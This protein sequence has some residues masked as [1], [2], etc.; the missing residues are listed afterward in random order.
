VNKEFMNGQSKEM[1]EVQDQLDKQIE[2]VKLIE[3][4]IESQDDR[5]FDQVMQ[6]MAGNW[7]NRI[8]KHSIDRS[9]LR[10]LIATLDIKYARANKSNYRA[11]KTT[12][13]ELYLPEDKSLVVAIIYQFFADNLFADKLISEW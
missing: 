6:R 5:I 10:S 9:H 2:T 1:S 13:E 7:F 12:Y 8:E 11:L 3:K 4:N